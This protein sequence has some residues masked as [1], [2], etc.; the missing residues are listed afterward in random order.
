MVRVRESE[1]RFV[2]DAGVSLVGAEKREEVARV[3]EQAAAKIRDGLTGGQVLDAAGEKVGVW[4]VALPRE[5]SGKTRM[6][7]LME[8][9]AAFRKVKR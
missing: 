6:R 5:V 7:E 4:S 3:L 2:A 9:D 8:E 1:F